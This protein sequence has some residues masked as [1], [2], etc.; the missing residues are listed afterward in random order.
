MGTADLHIHSTASDGLASPRDILDYAQDC[1]GLD[2]IAISDHDM[3]DGAL[4]AAALAEERRYR[5]EVMV[6]VEITTLE[7]HLLAYDI[8]KPIRMLQPLD[9]TLREIH[10]QGGFAVAPH[11]MSPLVRSIGRHGVLRVHRSTSDGVYFDGIELINPSLAGKLIYEKVV[12]LNEQLGLPPT[13]GS[14]SHTLETVGSAYTA[15]EGT[16]A[17]D[18]RRAL[19][20]S[21]TQAGGGFWGMAETRRLISIAGKQLYQSW[22]VLPGKHIRRNLK[23]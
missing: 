1:T 17:D 19:K 10:R 2:L 3:L 12:A 23:R 9:R 5:F 7:G 14:D 18:Y 6:G 11:P 20:A 21:R 16:T 8:Q 15:F 22:F 4:E 13:G